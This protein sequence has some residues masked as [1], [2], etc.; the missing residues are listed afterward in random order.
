MS[1]PILRGNQT[2]VPAITV[3]GG[4]AAIEFY[5]RA[6][7]AELQF[8]MTDPS[9][10]KVAYAELRVGGSYF[11][12]NDEVPQ[13]QALSPI[14]RGGPTGAI[15]LYVEDCDALYQQAVSAGATVK[16]PPM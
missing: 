7:G 9:S 14:T 3:N 1:K 5:K 2:I 10:D 4:K 15:N 8:L 12:L 11:T 13:V 6:F 16:M